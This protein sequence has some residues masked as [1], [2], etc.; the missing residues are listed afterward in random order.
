MSHSFTLTSE[1]GW[2][3]IIE[4]IKRAEHSIDCEL[5]IID[6]DDVGMYLLNAL[7]ERSRAGVK[8]RLLVDAGGSYLF[9][10]A[11]TLKAELRA[12]GIKLSFFN[13]FIPWYPRTLKLWYFRNHRRSITIDGKA[14]YTGGICFS[15]DMEGWRETMIRISEPEAVSDISQAYMRMWDLSENQRFDKRPKPASKD[16]LYLTN[17]PLPGKYYYYN[18]VMDLIKKSKN[19]IF[20][21]TPYFVPDYL[22]FNALYKAAKRGVAV[23]LLVPK[24]CNHP[25]VGYAGDFYK[26]RLIKKGARIYMYEK[27]MIHSKTGT[28]DDTACTIS[29]MN[30]DNVSLRYNFEGGLIIRDAVCI[31]EMKQ[32]FQDDIVGLEP[33]TRAKWRERPLREKVMMYLTWP[34]RKLL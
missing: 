25:L 26:E 2:M 16:W 30:L 29:S 28:F 32:Q 12:D 15:K 18:A 19:T 9:Y 10:L 14:S 7:R 4:D 31:T 23:H 20:L 27:S 34:I 1:A 17:A 22:F 21:T 3:A 13:H 24:I 11:S 5:F 6:I 8:V 33:L